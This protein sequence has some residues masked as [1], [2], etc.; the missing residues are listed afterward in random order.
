MRGRAK[1]ENVTKKSASFAAR[2]VRS[3][4]TMILGAGL[5][6]GDGGS[7]GE[8]GQEDV[9]NDNNGGRK[10][11]ANDEDQLQVMMAN[12]LWEEEVD[13]MAPWK[14]NNGRDDEEEDED[15]LPTDGKDDNDHDD[16]E[17]KL[18]S[19][20]E[21]VMHSITIDETILKGLEEYMQ[22]RTE[23]SDDDNMRLL[24]SPVSGSSS[25]INEEGFNGCLLTWESRCSGS[26]QPDFE[27][28]GGLRKN[29]FPATA[30]FSLD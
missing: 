20:W 28:L 15:I 24:P 30:T 8:S 7:D 12:N 22:E 29:L 18:L 9:D 14:P 1:G 11:E 27:V 25:P 19:S 26:F 23:D 6:G 17:D 2:A 21:D 10:N 16:D 3:M 5:S 13:G 4:T